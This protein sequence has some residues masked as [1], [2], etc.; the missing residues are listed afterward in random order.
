VD[1]YTTTKQITVGGHRNPG[2]KVIMSIA[3]A[4]AD[5]DDQRL[6]NYLLYDRPFVSVEWL[7]WG[8][9]WSLNETF[10]PYVGFLSSHGVFYCRL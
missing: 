4:A 5:F 7:E 1:H 9:T 2:V 8:K 6:I 10:T 3:A